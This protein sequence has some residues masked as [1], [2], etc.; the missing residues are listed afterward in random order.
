MWLITREL[1]EVVKRLVL[2][3]LNLRR[4]VR[5]RREVLQSG[6]PLRDLTRYERRI[7]SQNG[8]DG[9][10]QAIFTR[11]GTTNRY[12]VEFGARDGTQCN[13]R[14][15]AD[16]HGWRGL[17]L[18]DHYENP[19]RALHREFVTAEN[20]NSLF[21][22]YDVPT[23]FDL[24]SI[25]IDGNDLWVWNS[26]EAR[27]RPRVLVIE[28][29]SSTGP[30]ASLTIPYDEQF[31][32]DGTTYFGSSLQALCALAEHR[33]YA[34]IACDSRGV[35][36]FFVHADLVAALGEPAQAERVFRPPY[37]GRHLRGHPVSTQHLVPY[38]TGRD[39]LRRRGPRAPEADV[40]EKTK[41]RQGAART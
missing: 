5:F 13:T 37:Y 12:F 32:W 40:I 21:T 34:L 25:D 9:I 3:P 39:T 31:C 4:N 10:L 6:A 1:R 35:N 38:E 41:R 16:H 7:Y 36:A 14:Y 11:V 30:S 18:D 19:A 20:I 17:L 29:N 26:I 2:S 28:Y 24:L 27:W 8:E 23:E 33:G 22:K 15:L